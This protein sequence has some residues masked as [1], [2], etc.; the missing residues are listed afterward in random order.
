MHHISFL[1]HPLLHACRGCDGL[2][3]HAPEFLEVLSHRVQPKVRSA[4]A[5]S[6]AGNPHRGTQHRFADDFAASAAAMD[7]ERPEG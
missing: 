1:T 5:R 2:D 3:T 4:D 6:P 7:E